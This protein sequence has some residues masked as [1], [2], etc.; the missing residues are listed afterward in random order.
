MADDRSNELS[1]THRSTRVA[2]VGATSMAAIGGELW[3]QGNW[4][5]YDSLSAGSWGADAV[6]RRENSRPRIMAVRES[7]DDA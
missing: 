7:V 4:Q 2:V 3:R 5:Q 1:A 6:V